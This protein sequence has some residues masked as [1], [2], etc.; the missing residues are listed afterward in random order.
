M[1]L[2]IEKKKI[3]VLGGGQLGRMLIQEATKFDLDLWFMDKE[4]DFPVPSMYPNFVRGDFKNYDDVLAFGK[5]MDIITIEIE[6]VN[7]DALKELEAQGK[8]VYPQPRVIEIIK[9]K[10]IQKQFYQENSIPT[11]DFFL[12][13]DKEEIL[14]IIENGQLKLPFIQK[15]RLAGYDGKGVA[16]IITE[17]D[18]SKLLE[19]PAVIEQ[20]VDIEK[21][22][23]VILARNEDGAISAF[24]MTEMVFDPQG[25]LLDYLL[26][27]AAVDE[28][29]QQKGLELAKQVIEGLDMVGLLAV[30]LF[31]AKDGSILVNEVAPRPHNS[32]HHTIDAGNY[33]QYNMHLRTLLNWPLNTVKQDNM[34]M[35][36]NLLGSPDH[37]GPVKYEGLGRVMKIPNV[38]PHIYGKKITK[39]LRKM[40]HTTIVGDTLEELLEAKKFIKSYLKVISCQE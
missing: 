31:L 19:G 35:M 1:Y 37:T 12:V 29:I 22:L 3:G 25:N 21:E 14:K 38:Y 4:F 17:N 23:A 40:G 10:G 33:S 36:I 15:S 16:A 26:C 6:N 9:D 28:D 8:Q 24:P 30:E 2:I 34:A 13:S 5:A 39:P 7:T 20:L 11:S 18:L 27:P 32:G